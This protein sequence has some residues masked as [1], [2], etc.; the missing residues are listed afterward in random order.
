MEDVT[1]T[2]E[3]KILNKTLWCIGQPNNYYD[4]NDSKP[5][6]KDCN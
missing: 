2:E 5:N 1:Y 4:R 3:I 6:K